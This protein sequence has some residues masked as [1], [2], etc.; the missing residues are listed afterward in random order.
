MPCYSLDRGHRLT[1]RYIYIIWATNCWFYAGVRRWNVISGQLRWRYSSLLCLKSMNLWKILPCDYC[2]WLF[3]V[4]SFCLLLY[5]SGKTHIFVQW[6]IY[7]RSMSH[8]V[9][10]QLTFQCLL[11]QC[12]LQYWEMQTITLKSYTASVFD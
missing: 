11:T 9:F 10:L 8:N 6:N 4:H 12:H 7:L 1:W 3:I 2:V 5:D